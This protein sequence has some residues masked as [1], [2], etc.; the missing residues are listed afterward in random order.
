MEYKSYDELI[1]VVREFQS[2]N[3]DLPPDELTKLILRTFR[4]DRTI[5]LEID[6]TSDLWNFGS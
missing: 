6:G 3:K 5:L 1:K 2:Q 4:I